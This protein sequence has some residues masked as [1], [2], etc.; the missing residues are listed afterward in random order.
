MPPSYERQASRG[1]VGR[2][3]CPTS[4]D[5]PVPARKVCYAFAGEECA[6]TRSSV[7]SAR[8]VHPVLL[9]KPSRA[10]TL[11]ACITN[12]SGMKPDPQTGVPDPCD[13]ASMDN[14]TALRP[15]SGAFW[16]RRIRQARFAVTSAGRGRGGW[17]RCQWPLIARPVRGVPRGC[18]NDACNRCPALRCAPFPRRR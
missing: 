1:V 4:E 13:P 18:G 12:M 5:N 7:R 17:L 15:G 10:S 9:P 16:Q 14:L 11:P 8:S 2:A 6:R 3:L